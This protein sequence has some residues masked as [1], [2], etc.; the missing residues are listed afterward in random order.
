MENGN[1]YIYITIQSSTGYAHGS[2]L[3]REKNNIYTIIKIYNIARTMRY[4]LPPRT[5]ALLQQFSADAAV[6]NVVQY[7]YY[8]L[9]Y[10][11]YIL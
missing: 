1:I 3:R 10:Y 5:S 8:I 4:A 2:G 9:Y 6:Y 11:M 7:L